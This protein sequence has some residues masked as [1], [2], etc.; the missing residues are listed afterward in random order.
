MVKKMCEDIDRYHGE[1]KA[2]DKRG[3]QTRQKYQQEMAIK[4]MNSKERDQRSTH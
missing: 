2:R 3:A 4:T 1:H